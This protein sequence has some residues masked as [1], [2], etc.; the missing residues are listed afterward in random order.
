MDPATDI[1]TGPASVALSV[2]SR[3]ALLWARGM[4]RDHL[5]LME[6]ADG[7]WVSDRD[8][9]DV[10]K[11]TGFAC[12]CHRLTREDGTS[13]LNGAVL[14]PE[15]LAVVLELLTGIGGRVALTREDDSGRAPAF[16][17]IEPPGPDYATRPQ[18]RQS[19]SER[20]SA[21]NA[22]LAELPPAYHSFAAEC[23]LSWL[24]QFKLS[25]P[26]NGTRI[27]SPER[28]PGFPDLDI[29]TDLA[30]AIARTAPWYQRFL[31][32][33]LIDI[34]K[35]ELSAKQVDYPPAAGAGLEISEEWS[36]D[37]NGGES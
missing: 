3:M 35:S 28:I 32:R 8:D 33:R 15:K 31:C 16:E 34:C 4:Y 20:L 11:W 17:F 1:E 25:S 29:L 19:D 9:G 14:H 37:F 24:D 13:V 30:R 36:P 21:V 5:V 26:W 27:V 7:L 6:T 23:I 2:K 12:R 10:V 22:A 18:S